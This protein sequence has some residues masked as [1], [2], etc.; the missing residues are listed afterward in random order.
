[1]AIQRQAKAHARKLSER[2]RRWAHTERAETLGPPALT[3]VNTCQRKYDYVI[4]VKT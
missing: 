1:M 4:C 3:C 2:I